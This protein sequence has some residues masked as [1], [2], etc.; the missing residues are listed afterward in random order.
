MRQNASPWCFI[1][2]CF[3]FTG[4]RDERQGEV[5]VNYWVF[6]YTQFGRGGGVQTGEKSGQQNSCLINGEWRC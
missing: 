4:F 3:I 6:N 5:M 1:A 2:Y